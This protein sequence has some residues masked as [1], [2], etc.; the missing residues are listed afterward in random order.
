M[1]L[2]PQCTKCHKCNLQ[3]RSSRR[4]H[5]SQGTHGTGG[6]ESPVKDGVNF[7]EHVCCKKL[8]AE[9]QLCQSDSRP[10]QKRPEGTN[11]EGRKFCLGFWFQNFQ[12]TAS[13][14]CHFGLVARQSTVA[15]LLTYD[16]QEGER[17]R[18]GER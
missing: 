7:P 13:G 8:L 17:G 9:D 3:F 18:G 14:L 10:C 11:L 4:R 5:G 2:F 15:K 6:L 16:N 12:F 1:I